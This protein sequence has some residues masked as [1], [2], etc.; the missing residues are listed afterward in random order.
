MGCGN[1]KKADDV[2]APGAAPAGEEWY[3]K[4][5]TN[6]K[7]LT[8]KAGDRIGEAYDATKP[9]AINLAE[10]T[11]KATKDAAAATKEFCLDVGDSSK[12][13]SQMAL[14]QAQLSSADARLKHTKEEFGEKVF[15]ALL[16]NMP[17]EGEPVDAKVIGDLRVD[18]EAL[19]VYQDA[20]ATFKQ[21]LQDMDDVR[22]EIAELKEG[23]KKTWSENR[24]VQKKI[25]ADFDKIEKSAE[26]PEAELAAPAAA[27]VAAEAEAVPAPAPAEEVKA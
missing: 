10:K 7:E 12:A 16:A 19:S 14:L 13:Y 5:L 3:M 22:K 24:E 17:A 27:P 15:K 25:L 18:S 11:W 8:K 6:A 4:A 2:S 20:M 9:H 23:V 1:S 26:L 21:Q